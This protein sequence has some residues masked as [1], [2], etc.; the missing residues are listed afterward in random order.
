[1][2]WDLLYHQDEFWE[3][4]TLITACLCLCAWIKRQTCVFGLYLEMV[5]RAITSSAAAHQL[6]WGMQEWI[7]FHK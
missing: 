3:C 4:V 2:A 7:V 1:M 5:I 6:E